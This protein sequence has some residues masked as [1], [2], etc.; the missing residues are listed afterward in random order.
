MT[1]KTYIK[2]QFYLN[3]LA[4]YTQGTVF[5]IRWHI[6]LDKL[7]CVVGQ[8]L[9]RSKVQSRLKKI[10]KERFSKIHFRVQCNYLN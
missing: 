5:N 9:S 8:I 3:Q 4:I 6:V 7:T 2:W 1:F 10:L